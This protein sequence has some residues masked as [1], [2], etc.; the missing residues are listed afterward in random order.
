MTV[1]TSDSFRLPP[2][3]TH[4]RLEGMGI[5]PKMTGLTGEP[6]LGDPA[7]ASGIFTIELQEA[8]KA[9]ENVA[10]FPKD[11][12]VY[13]TRRW[14]DYLLTST[15][16]E[17]LEGTKAVF[18]GSDYDT[19]YA[20]R[21]VFKN[22]AGLLETT[23]GL[24][25]GQPHFV[26]GAILF[27]AHPRDIVAQFS[28]ACPDQARKIK[29]DDIEQ[30]LALVA[31][32]M[33]IRQERTRSTSF[34]TGVIECDGIERPIV[35]ASLGKLAAWVSVIDFACR[36]VGQRK[37]LRYVI[38]LRGN[39][40]TMRRKPGLQTGL[41]QLLRYAWQDNDNGTDDEAMQLKLAH[42]GLENL[43]YLAK[44]NILKYPDLKGLGRLF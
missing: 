33:G 41:Q 23:R 17:G 37:D 30:V 32:G 7:T 19:K 16:P 38:G 21:A 4:P 6:E 1:V 39:P 36:N 42:A 34:A 15:V 12:T 28:K 9:I 35:G 11:G 20:A 25:S 43:A 26:S 40:L 13:G 8:G 27:A 29:A 22:N 14:P 24:A 44:L 5:A 18:V 31:G 10:L 3:D 2:L